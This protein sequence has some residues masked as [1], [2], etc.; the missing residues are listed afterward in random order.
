MI[1]GNAYEFAIELDLVEKIDTWCYGTFNFIIDGDFIPGKYV[2]YTLGV[3]IH[4]LKS[5]FDRVA[6]QS[7]NDLGERAVDVNKLNLGEEENIFN[8]DAGELDQVGVLLW[9]GYSGDEERLFYSGDLGQTY[10]EKRLPRGTVESV[11]RSLPK[12]EDL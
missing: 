1:V 7:I 8:I 10:K 12:P 2:D 9:L 4:Y 5:S 11:I 6:R 3:V